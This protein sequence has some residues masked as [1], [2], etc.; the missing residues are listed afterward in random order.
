MK[1]KTKKSVKTIKFSKLKVL[2][3]CNS[4]RLPKRIWVGKQL[5]EWVGIGW[6]NLDDEDADGTE[7]TVIDG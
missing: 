7:P 6:I 5:K 1:H 4:P 3:F 2:E